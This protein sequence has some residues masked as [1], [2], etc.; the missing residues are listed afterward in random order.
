MLRGNDGERAG[1]GWQC[2]RAVAKVSALIR[3]QSADYCRLPKTDGPQVRVDTLLV[4]DSRFLS[5][6]MIRVRLRALKC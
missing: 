5:N 4:G 2:L 1:C 6:V 3:K